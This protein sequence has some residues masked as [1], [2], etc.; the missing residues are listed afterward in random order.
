ME[1][2]SSSPLRRKSTYCDNNFA[3]YTNIKCLCCTSETNIMLYFNYISKIKFKKRKI[4]TP[5]VWSE[6]KLKSLSHVWLFATPWTPW[7]SPSQNTGV[8]SHSL[9]KGIFQT[10]GSDLN[11]LHCRQILHHLNNQGSPWSRFTGCKNR[12]WRWH[13]VHYIVASLQHMYLK[14]W[15]MNLELKF[16]T[17]YWLMHLSS[18]SS[19]IES[20]FLILCEIVMAK[21]KCWFPTAQIW[22]ILSLSVN[23]RK[24]D[25]LNF[26]KHLDFWREITQVHTRIW[27][28][29]M[30]I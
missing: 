3:I 1:Y 5:H 15:N 17:I 24:Y 11:L 14:F 8:G 12:S 28:Y 22:E 19:M 9:L 10:Q 7:N 16:K 2:P 13:I 21:V 29:F 23:A 20:K 4:N 25:I 18:F 6:V 27:R 26:W 30:S